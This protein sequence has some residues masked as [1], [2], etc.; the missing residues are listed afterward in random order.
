M[1]VCDS[2]SKI[3]Q[4]NHADL[5]C[6][7][8]SIS[9]VYHLIK[10]DQVMERLVISTCSSY[11][12]LPKPL[13]DHQ[14]AM[15]KMPRPTPSLRH[16]Y[17]ICRYTEVSLPFLQNTNPCLAITNITWCFAETCT[18]SGPEQSILVTGMLTAYTRLTGFCDSR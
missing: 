3:L 12:G 5:A 16:G 11:I 6:S 17:N 8:S 14:S 1:P 18:P 7:V 10:E 9:I 4:P 15:K 13:Q 2:I